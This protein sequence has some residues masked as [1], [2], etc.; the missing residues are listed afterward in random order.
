M[1]AVRRER[2]IADALELPHRFGRE[3][4]GGLLRGHGGGREDDG[5]RDAADGELHGWLP[6]G[7]RFGALFNAADSAARWP[8]MANPIRRRNRTLRRIPGWRT[9]SPCGTCRN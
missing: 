9:V 4:Q 8:R 1:A 2:G 3:R 6:G 5:D 7:A